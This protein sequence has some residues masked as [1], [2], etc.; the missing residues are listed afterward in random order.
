MK[1]FFGYVPLHLN[2]FL[3]V[4]IYIQYQFQLITTTLQVLLFGLVVLACQY[5]LRSFFYLRLA[6]SFLFLGSLVTFL[7]SPE[8]QTHFYQKHQKNGDLSQLVIEEVLRATDYDMRYIA[9]VSQI[10]QR[11]TTGSVLLIVAKDTLQTPLAVDDNIVGYFEYDALPKA[12]HPHQFNYAAYLKKQYVYQQIRTASPYFFRFENSTRS[13]L[14]IAASFRS[15]IQKQ[16]RHYGFTGET[17]AVFNA[18]VLGERTGLSSAVRTQYANAGAIHILA[19]SGLHVGIIL[20]LLSFL[21]KPLERIPK[22][23]WIKTMLL[24]LLLWAFAFVV[25]LSP[26]VVRAVTMFSAVAIGLSFQQK[27]QVLQALIISLFVLLLCKP[28]FLFDVGFQ[29]SY[30][31]VFAI[32]LFQPILQQLW[33]PKALLLKSIWQLITVSLAAQLG[34]FPV[35]L[36]Y[37]HQFPGL[38]MVSN[39]VILPLLGILLAGGIFVITLA[40]FEV[41]PQFLADGYGYCIE[42]LN[43]FVAFVAQQ[44][45]FLIADITFS[46]P[47]VFM[48]YGV[49][50][51]FYFTFRFKKTKLLLY[52]LAGVICI[53]AYGLYRDFRRDATAQMIVFH[54]SSTTLVGFQHGTSLLLYSTVNSEILKGFVPLQSYCIGEDLTPVITNS[55]PNVFVYANTPFLVIDSLGVYPHEFMPNGIVLLSQNPPIHVARMIDL[56]KPSLIVADGSNYRST[57]QLWKQTCALRSIDF[58]YTGTQGAFVYN[59]KFRE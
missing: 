44:E 55:V 18:L 27:P 6:L 7:H 49:L 50:L 41:L 31:A 20:G 58:W 45:D 56:I 53:Q 4:G 13:L 35:S 40:C 48:Y 39:I 12:L 30:L 3:M 34:V 22:G 57:I 17:Y 47:S 5:I 51:L 36:F 43:T 28:L 38:F 32:V 59:N 16:L 25:G 24:L 29:L 15:Y 21:F 23:R 37:F 14:G 26:S 2:L 11:K 1:S 10:N 52:S 54:K 9:R 19:V 33:K 46:L 8:E 42:L